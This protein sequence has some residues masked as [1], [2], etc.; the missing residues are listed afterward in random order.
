MTG[1]QISYRDPVEFYADHAAEFDAERSRA[2][3]ERGW[4]DAF[5]AEIPASGT[6]LDLGCGAGEPMAG[7]MIDRGFAVTGVDASAPLLALAQ[8]RYPHATWLNRDMRALDIGERFDG[9]LAWDSFFHLSA[10]AQRACI[11]TIATHARPHAA[12]MFT[13][14]DDHGEAINPLF[15]EPLY[16]ASLSRHEYRALLA[17]Q[18]FHVLRHVAQDR[19][20]GD[21]AIWLAR[22]GPETRN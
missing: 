18:G 3:K 14:G 1:D 2:L 21:R 16:H 10:E 12:L 9:I 17:A 4:L 13:S 20:C 6:I 19:T 8:A 15:G 7:Y 5:L 22:R 11:T